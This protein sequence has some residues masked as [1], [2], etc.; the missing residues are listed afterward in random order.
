MSSTF[1]QMQ[2]QKK[3]KVICDCWEEQN[4]TKKMEAM[5]K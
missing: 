3:S 2:S 5:L 4:W 1:T